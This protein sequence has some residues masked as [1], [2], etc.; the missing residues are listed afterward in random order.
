MATM[1]ITIE[2]NWGFELDITDQSILGKVETSLWSVV[3]TLN[4]TS[5]KGL[6][7]HF[8]IV[9]WSWVLDNLVAGDEVN[10]TDVYTKMDVW[11]NKKR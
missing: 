7:Q 5:M 3:Q 1:R 9:V 11:N 10:F 8:D 4:A 6:K 2:Q